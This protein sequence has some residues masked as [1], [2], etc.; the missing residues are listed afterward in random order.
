[1]DQIPYASSAAV[2]L[3]YADDQ[4]GEP[5]QCFGVVV[6]TVENRKIV[7]ASFSSVKFPGRAPDG[8]KLIRVFL[9]GALQPQLMNLSDEQ[10]QELA[11]VEISTFLRIVGKPIRTW[12]QRWQEKMPQYHVGHVGLIDSMEE[13]VAN[14]Q[15]LEI[16]GNAYRGVGIPQC[17]QSGN[18]AAMRLAA[19][20][21]VTR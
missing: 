8:R 10:L 18:E 9:G 19:S 16:A 5:L 21:T 2:N 17:I 7:A 12:V 6:P 11:H 14:Y 20:L 1:M 13:Q 3:S 4:L 15:G